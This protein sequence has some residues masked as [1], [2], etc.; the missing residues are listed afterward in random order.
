MTCEM[1][2]RKAGWKVRLRGHGVD[3]RDYLLC[4]AHYASASIRTRIEI[5]FARKIV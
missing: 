4:L 3:R 5:L 2:H 1:C